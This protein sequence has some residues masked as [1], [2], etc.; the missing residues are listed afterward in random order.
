MSELDPEW[1]ESRWESDRDLT[2]DIEGFPSDT[3]YGAR[4]AGSSNLQVDLSEIVVTADAFGIP[5][6][7]LA[8]LFDQA[9]QIAAQYIDHPKDA[10]PI[11]ILS[12]WVRWLPNAVPERGLR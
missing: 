8:T 11:A 10:R 4:Q 1:P 2:L 5:A 9:N 3:D 6:D 7:Q 12:L